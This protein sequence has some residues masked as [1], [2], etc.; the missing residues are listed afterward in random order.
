MAWEKNRL[1]VGP[2]LP[3]IESGRMV[4][5]NALA[6]HIKNMYVTEAG[7]LRAVWGPV[8]Y[9]PSKFPDDQQGGYN[10]TYGE[11][12]LGLFHCRVE[13]GQRDI[14]LAHYG[15]YIYEHQGW[16][17]GEVD[18]VWQRLIGPKQLVNP[19]VFP[20]V[21]PEND[22]RPSF[23]TQFE[24]TPNGVVIVPQGGRA[25]FFDG[26]TVLPLGYSEIPGPPNGRG[27][28]TAKFA[29]ETAGTNPETDG[30]DLPNKGGY[31]H[32]GQHPDNNQ[33]MGTY[34]LG[35]IRND[36]AYPP[37]LKGAKKI[38][39]LGG[40][41]E[42]SEWRAALQFVDIWGNVSP[43][44]GLSNAIKFDKSQNCWSINKDEDNEREETSDRLRAQFLWDSIA[45]GP[46]GTIGRILCR[47]KD[48][49]NSGIPGIFEVRN[50][51]AVGSLEFATMPDNVATLFPDN[52]PDSWLVARPAD[53]V[54]VP[55]F[56]LCRV[57]FGRLWIANW[58][59]GQG[60][61]RPSKPLFWGTFPKGQEI[62][63]DP[64]GAEITAMWTTQ[65]GLLV[66][67][68]TSTFLVIP[69]TSGEG[70]RSATL[71]TEIGCV[72][73]DS[74]KT[75]PN[76][77]SVWL[78]RTGFFSYDG[79]S[80]KKISID[81][82][83]SVIRRINKARALRACAA[84]DER[85]EEYRCAVPVDG[86]TTN[87]LILVYDGQGWRERDDIKIRAM[88]T[89]RDHRKYMLALGEVACIDTMTTLP[90]DKVSVW[91]MDHDGRGVYEPVPHEGLVET[92]WLQ[93]AGS[94][95][96]K[97]PVRIR[98]WLRETTSGTLNV[99]VYRD[100][101]ETPEVETAV[102]PD[103]YPT[104]DPPP[105]WNEAILG[106]THVDK[107]RPNAEE[108]PINN[109]WSKRRPHW[110]VADFMAPA[111]EVYKLRFTYTGDWDFIGIV[112]E[113]IATDVGGANIPG[114][115]SG[116]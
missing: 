52:I 15:D 23:L 115:R 43:L 58:S 29:A 91:V 30:D 4:T 63:P 40:I 48:L 17:T 94:F 45:R 99:K 39:P 80:I 86:S 14:L 11:P 10:V 54:P 83:E 73:P 101:R 1:K 25:Y 89:T 107:L 104:D 68:A 35:S 31:S 84:V 67:T 16:D 76:G 96:R 37:K 112:F 2:T 113:E 79:K 32:N 6:G 12:Y 81:I 98:I 106:G 62:F 59:G 69:N 36:M 50:Q 21:L 8:E 57:A 71:N 70:F 102:S 53:P 66:F 88:C 28:Q 7:T 49:K 38:N 111:S 55:M 44:S 51:S 22:N 105:F 85:S 33:V 114:G 19:P 95:N 100:W 109:S 24:A 75:M 26:T 93:A 13:G 74:I 92:T 108:T 78:A 103:L 27:P 64:S 41:L 34:R 56:K 97:S 18:K 42:A 77:T 3:R 82:E 20:A 65:F 72:S 9:I 110:V 116:V 47:T 5:T 90:V 61:I 46:D 87:N 60:T